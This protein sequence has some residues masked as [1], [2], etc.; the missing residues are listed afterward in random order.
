M[1]HAEVSS[2]A[3]VVDLQNAMLFA[4]HLAKIPAP[5]CRATTNHALCVSITNARNAHTA[6]LLEW[7]SGRDYATVDVNGRQ[8]LARQFG[9]SG[10]SIIV[11]TQ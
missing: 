7:V 11:I 5:Y 6:R 4:L 3:G 10:C 9:E 1:L 8:L 2:Q